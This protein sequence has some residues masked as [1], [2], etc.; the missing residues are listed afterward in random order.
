M[1]LSLS[2]RSESCDKCGATSM[3]RNRVADPV[4]GLGLGLCLVGREFKALG[5]TSY[6]SDFLFMASD[7]A[8]CAFAPAHPL[9]V[10][11]VSM[12]FAVMVRPGRSST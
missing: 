1:S 8:S 3:T 12:D 6:S 2:L 5:L 7:E 11:L 9:G 4:F 10:S